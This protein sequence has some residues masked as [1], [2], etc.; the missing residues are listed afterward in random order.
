MTESE[1]RKKTERVRK[2]GGQIERHTGS[3]REGHSVGRV[4]KTVWRRRAGIFPLGHWMRSAGCILCLSELV[5]SHPS[6]PSL[7]LIKLNDS[8]YIVKSRQN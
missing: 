1:R 2:S 4:F 5:G 7:H 8:L 6:I 3:R